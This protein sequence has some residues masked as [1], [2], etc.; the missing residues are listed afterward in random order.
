MDSRAVDLRKLKQFATEALPRNSILR[1]LILSERDAISPGDFCAKS[2]L[3]LKL[4][5]RREE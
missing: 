3:W 4:L 1:D 5:H 2:E